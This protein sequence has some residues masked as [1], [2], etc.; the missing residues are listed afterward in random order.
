MR[1]RRSGGGFESRAPARRS[2]SGATGGRRSRLGVPAARPPWAPLRGHR[3]P[4]TPGGRRG[5]G[6]TSRCSRRPTA[7]GALR[8]HG[9]AGCCCVGAGGSSRSKTCWTWAACGRRG[10]PSPAGVAGRCG[11][12]LARAGLFLRTPVGRRRWPSSGRRR[13]RFA[14]EEGRRSRNDSGRNGGCGLRS[15]GRWTPRTPRGRTCRGTKSTSTRS[16]PNPRLSVRQACALRQVA[17]TAL[18]SKRESGRPRQPC[19]ASG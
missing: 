16:R 5:P 13:Q 8:G 11:S 18:A 6:A 17:V 19:R 4:D 14:G 7:P 10:G 9:L 2:P 12:R 15:S 1:T 3:L